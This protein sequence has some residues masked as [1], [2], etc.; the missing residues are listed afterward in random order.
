MIIIGELQLLNCYICDDLTVT[1]PLVL[2]IL[3]VARIVM[4]VCCQIGRQLAWNMKAKGGVCSKLSRVRIK[5]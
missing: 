1:S 4:L 3:L 2:V 5:A